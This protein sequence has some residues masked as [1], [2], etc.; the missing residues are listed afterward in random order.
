MKKKTKADN[1]LSLEVGLERT[2]ISPKPTEVQKRKLTRG[3]ETYIIVQVHNRLFLSSLIMITLFAAGAKKKLDNP[4][5][6]S[7]WAHEPAVHCLLNGIGR[8]LHLFTSQRNHSNLYKDI[9]E[10]DMAPLGFKFTVKECQDKRQS[11]NAY[12]CR[13]AKK[14]GFV[15]ASKWPFYEA[16]CYIK[17]GTWPEGFMSGEVADVPVE[18]GMCSLQCASDPLYLCLLFIFSNFM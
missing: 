18:N 11:L 9:I 3:T 8:R 4:S 15:G 16:L 12:F 17:A 13:A 2:R 10:T 6:S 5:V 14:D 7:S 1:L